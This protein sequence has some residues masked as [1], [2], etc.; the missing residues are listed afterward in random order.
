M[1]IFY[2]SSST[3]ISQKANS[4][5]V[6]K[7]C[8]A[9]SKLGHNVVLFAKKNQK[10]LNNNLEDIKKYYGIN[11]EFD[12]RLIKSSSIRLFGGLEYG[13]KVLKTIKELRIKPDIFYGRNLYALINCVHLNKPIIYESHAVPSLGRKTLEQYL[14]SKP[15]F[16]RLV[17]INQ[18]LFSYYK[19]NFKI[20]IKHPEK[21]CLAPDGAGINYNIRTNIINKIP[22]IGYAGSLYPGKGIETIIKI[23]NKLPEYKFVVA[24]GTPQQINQFNENNNITFKGYINPSNIP[25]FL[26]SC[27]ILLAPYSNK[28]YSEILKKI[29]IVNWMSPLK[30]FE[31]MASKKP[32]IASNLPEIKEILEDKK[33]AYLVDH[34]NITGWKN[35]I[36]KILCKPK[37]ANSIAENA[38]MELKNKYTWD[39]R[40]KRVLENL[41]IKNLANNGSKIILHVIG[42]LNIGGTERNMLKI[43]PR[44]NKNGFKHKILTLFELGT[45]ATKFQKLGIEVRTLNIPKQSVNTKTFIGIMSL[46]KE[47]KSIKPVIIHSWLYHSNNI[48]N[49]ISPFLKNIKIINSIRHDNPNTGSIKTRISSKI[50]A[51]ISK[52]ANNPIIFCSESSLLKHLN[53]GYSNKYP[54]VIENG[55]IIPQIDKKYCQKRLKD[56]FNIPNDY[57]IAINVGRFCLEKDYPTLFK[58]IELLLEKYSKIVFIFCG[59][60]LESNNKDLTKLITNT[61]IMNNLILLGNKTNIEEYIAGADFLVSSSKSES[62]PNVIAEAMSLSIPCIATN[63]GDTEKII[64][65][66]GFIVE[67]QKPVELANAMLR[68]LQTD[69]KSINRLSNKANNRI[70]QNYTLEHCVVKYLDLYNKLL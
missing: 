19:N 37:I 63:T 20:F 5:Q 67:T 68:F 60:G 46:L 55:F 35:T 29:N 70:K 18:A 9:F 40:A 15:Q 17:V 3:I 7:M 14:F 24:G 21:L 11:N 8:D 43:I 56:R 32:I 42:D 28:V 33:T 52:L 50:G 25:E 61:N 51:Y 66:T 44:L 41:S 49:L 31:Y 22:I 39:R 69:E 47:I 45:L 64:G 23:A 53:I 59:K 48:V 12:I 38:F 4:V 34:N 2:L 57:K 30:I 36:V 6:M 62:F 54:L 26:S 58:A 27:D 16:I 65:D 13:Y 1:N 10:E